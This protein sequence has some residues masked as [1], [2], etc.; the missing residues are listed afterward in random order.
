MIRCLSPEQTMLLS[1]YGLF[2]GPVTNVLVVPRP[3]GLLGLEP[4]KARNRASTIPLGVF[5]KYPATGQPA[6]NDPA[7]WEGAPVMLLGARPLPPKRS[8][9]SGVPLSEKENE[10]QSYSVAQ[11][12]RQVLEAE[13]R[14][15]V[16]AVQME[17]DKVRSD[18]RRAL[19]NGQGWHE[20]YQ[21]LMSF[22]VEE[23][24]NPKKERKDFAREQQQHMQ[25]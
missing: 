18:L 12:D 14:E 7:P 23:I 6:A 2:S 8:F 24:L 15:T 20:V 17:V 4:I 25:A 1:M 3:Q 13:T 16:A 9:P 10:D 21:D 19:D 11:L 5:Q 22:C